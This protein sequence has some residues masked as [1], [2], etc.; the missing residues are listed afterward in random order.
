MAVSAS[1]RSR[2]ACTRR[3]S[4]RMPD[5]Y[6]ESLRN[7]HMALIIKNREVIEDDWTVVR[8]GEDG[9]LPAVDAVLP[10]KAIVPFTWWKEHK[11]ALTAAHK[12]EP[13]G[14]WLAPDDEPA[15]LVEDFDKI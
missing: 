12:K 4:R 10:A 9:T 2:N 13:I 3:A 1:H 11:N 14:V 7:K 6:V 8:A 15:E 5:C